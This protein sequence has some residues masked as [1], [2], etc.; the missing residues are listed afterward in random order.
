MIGNVCHTLEHHLAGKA[1]IE[2]PLTLANQ[3]LSISLVA[4]GR[5]P[6]RHAAPARVAQGLRVCRKRKQS[7]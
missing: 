3:R 2:K 5:Y 7:R 6:V 4:I 1:T